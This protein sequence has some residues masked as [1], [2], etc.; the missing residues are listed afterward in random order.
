MG[1][2]IIKQSI[3]LI[4]TMAIA[5]FP[6]LSFISQ[7][8]AAE[9]NSAV[10]VTIAQNKQENKSAWDLV[11][12]IF[13]RKKKEGGTMG[14]FCSISPNINAYVTWSDRPLFVWEGTVKEI[15]VLL[16]GNDTALWTYVVKGNEKQV[17][18]NVDNT[19]QS[20]QTGKE[21]SYLVMYEAIGNEGKKITDSKSIPFQVMED[22][23]RQEIAAQLE[24]LNNQNNTMTAEELAIK[25]SIFFGDFKE[26][27]LF[28]DVV[29]E[30]FSVSGESPEWKNM[31]QKIR[32]EFCQ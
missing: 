5:I 14:E 27:D 20:L 3:L 26:E 12:E 2:S 29:R 22:E 24:A 16:P 31:T 23:K 18:Y 7:S 9:K 13:S 32:S 1:R 25:R 15:K 17:L 10:G 21:Y 30:V 11:A 4:S 8:W 28:L 19:G 6:A